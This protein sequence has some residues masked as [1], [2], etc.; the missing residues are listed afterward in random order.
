MLPTTRGTESEIITQTWQPGIHDRD[1]PNG[2][3]V[4]EVFRTKPVITRATFDHGVLV[5]IVMTAISMTLRCNDG[6]GGFA[7]AVSSL[8]FHARSF[9]AISVTVTAKIHMIG[10]LIG[11]VARSMPSQPGAADS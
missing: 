3:L 1:A 2:I 11:K 8:S 9:D 10:K 4:V 6:R 7:H 5:A